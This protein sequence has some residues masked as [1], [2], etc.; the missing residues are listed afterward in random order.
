MSYNR[1]IN[2]GEMGDTSEQ[3]IIYVPSIF[4]SATSLKLGKYS[5]TLTRSASSEYPSNVHTATI[6]GDGE[7]RDGNDLRYHDETVAESLDRDAIFGRN[8]KL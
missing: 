8:T 6:D 4:S 2:V 5:V 7:S 3:E 1:L